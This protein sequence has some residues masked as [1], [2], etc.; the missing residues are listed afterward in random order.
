M[1]RGMAVL[2]AVVVTLLAAG[3]GVG[4]WWLLRKPGPQRPEISAY[5]HGQLI[6]VG[7]YLYCN[8]LN[9]D[10]CQQPQAQGELRVSDNYPV[11][12]SV[13]EAISRAPWRLLQVYEDPANTATTMFRPG[14]RLAVTIPSVDPQRGRLTGIVVQLLTLVVDPAGELHDVPHAEWSVRMTH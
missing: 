6:R 3:A 13:P 5:S 14:T 12:L 10:D 1:K 4:T 9:L 2:L 7:P 11:Q 8:V